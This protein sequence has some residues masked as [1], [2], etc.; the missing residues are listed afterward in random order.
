MTEDEVVGWHH[1]LDGL[2]CVWGS[3]RRY[4]K[5]RRPGMLQSMGSQSDTREQLN[6]NKSYISFK[7]AFQKLRFVR[8]ISFKNQDVS[9]IEY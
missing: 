8:I 1:Q 5:T 6:N 2:T 3:S 4:R 9:L 7:T